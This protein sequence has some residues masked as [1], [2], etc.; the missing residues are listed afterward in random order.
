MRKRKC[1]N[2]NNFPGKRKQK[3]TIILPLSLTKEKQVKSLEG[4]KPKQI[5]AHLPTQFNITRFT[6]NL[7]SNVVVT[8]FKVL[9]FTNCSRAKIK[10]QRFWDSG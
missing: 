5:G 10:Q 1:H 2:K 6:R 7:N 4:D 8:T 3:K 9:H